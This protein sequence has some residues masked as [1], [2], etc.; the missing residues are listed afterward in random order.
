MHFPTEIAVLKNNTNAT[1]QKH[2][3]DRMGTEPAEILIFF[4]IF[5]KN[6]LFYKYFYKNIRRP[7]LLSTISYFHGTFKDFYIIYATIP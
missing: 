1:F 3:W 2:L 6:W 5:S 4:R 7:F